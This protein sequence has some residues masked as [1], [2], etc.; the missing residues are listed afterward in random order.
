MALFEFDFQGVP[1]AIN[2]RAEAFGEEPLRRAERA[3]AA[4]HEA[5]AVPA[6]AAEHEAAAARAANEARPPAPLRHFSEEVST[7]VRCTTDQ[8]GMGAG[9]ALRC[10]RCRAVHP[11]VATRFV[12]TACHA[13]LA[14]RTRDSS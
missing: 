12:C 9:T 6:A 14:P 13:L 7:A 11:L 10:P 8:A 3:A 1:R 5:A 4:E 2:A